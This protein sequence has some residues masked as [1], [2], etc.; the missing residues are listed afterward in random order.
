MWR[1]AL[2]T[3]LEIHY[4]YLGIDLAKNHFYTK[5]TNGIFFS[6]QT[7]ILHELEG[8][9]S[10]INYQQ[11]YRY[12]VN[13]YKSLHKYENTFYKNIFELQPSTSWII[14]SE[15]NIKKIKYWVNLIQGKYQ[16]D[17]IDG[18]KHHLKESLD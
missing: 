17:A 4:L 2:L 16:K 13:G 12:L 1:F 18:V 7:N 3:R 15:L 5:N 11:I 10:E 8:K 6:S 9:K 14:N